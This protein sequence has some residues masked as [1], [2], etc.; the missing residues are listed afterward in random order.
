MV[1]LREDGYAFRGLR[2]RRSTSR[3]EELV[4]DCRDLRG[5]ESGGSDHPD[6]GCTGC[7]YQKAADVI[8]TDVWVSMGEPDEVWAERVRNC[9][10]IR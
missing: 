3:I 8:Y 9:T 6:G 5:T 7:R 10:R 4:E 2:F 1:R